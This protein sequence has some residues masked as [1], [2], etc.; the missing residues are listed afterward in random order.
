MFYNKR[1][2]ELSQSVSHLYYQPVSYL[3]CR[4]IGQF[5]PSCQNSCYRQEELS[6]TARTQPINCYLQL[7]GLYYYPYSQNCLL[8]LSTTLALS[9]GILFPHLLDCYLR[10]H[11]L[12]YSMYLQISP[13]QITTS[14]GSLLLR[15]SSFLI[16]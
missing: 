12:I 11:Y 15:C 7:A 4:V 8:A 6:T 1:K 14:S 10:K 2:R 13:A 5:H 3:S 16:S 9:T